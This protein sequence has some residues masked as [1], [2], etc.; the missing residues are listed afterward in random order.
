V[1][2]APYGVL[3]LTLNQSDY[4]WQFIPIA[5][6]TFTDA[7]TGACHGKPNLTNQPPTARPAAPTCRKRRSRLTASASSD[8][9][10]QLP[11]AYAWNFGDGTTGTGV[12]PTHTYAANGTYTVTLVVTD[13]LGAPSTPATTT[14]TIGN[15]PPTVYAGTGGSIPVG[16]MFAGIRDVLRSG[17]RFPVYVH[18]SVGRRLE[19]IEYEVGP[20]SDLRQSRLCGRRHV[21]HPRECDG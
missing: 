18:D 11:L 17:Q 13:N 7:G 14:A 19:R 3:K 4:A 21:H 8:P 16:S 5:G 6:Q 12:N 20:E 9:E 2:A 10:N 1:L 15:I